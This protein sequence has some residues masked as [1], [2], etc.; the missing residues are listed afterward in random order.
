MILVEAKGPWAVQTMERLLQKDGAVSDTCFSLLVHRECPSIGIR[1]EIVEEVSYVDFMLDVVEPGRLLEDSIVSVSLRNS[2]TAEERAHAS[3]KLENPAP[4]PARVQNPVP[5]PAQAP[6]LRV[7]KNS[8]SPPMEETP[9]YAKLTG[10]LIH[11]G[12]KKADVKKFIDSLGPRLHS[13]KIE[14][15]IRLGI[16]ELAA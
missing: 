10:G 16:K 3:R 15:L 6:V 8:M 2:L 7:V 5:V 1:A 4:V 12:F 13:E 14:D 9:T 11:L